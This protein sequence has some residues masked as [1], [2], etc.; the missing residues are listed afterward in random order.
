MRF[1]KLRSERDTA[2]QER[3]EL[4]EQVEIAQLQ[5]KHLEKMLEQSQNRERALKE[6]QLKQEIEIATRSIQASLL[7][8]WGA[9]VASS[10]A[11]RR[12]LQFKS[13]RARSD[14]SL[15]TSSVATWAQVCR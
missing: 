4:L 15:L 12:V 9:A 2:L 8:V 6:R 5:A 1:E 3:C 14:A 10:K 13:S 11:T 7:R